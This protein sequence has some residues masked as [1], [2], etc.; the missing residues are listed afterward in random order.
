MPKKAYSGA[1]TAV[2]G[3]YILIILGGS[4]SSGTNIS[5]KNHLGTSFALFFWSGIAPNGSEGQYLAQNE[6]K[7]IYL[8]KVR[9]KSYF[10]CWKRSK[11]FGTHISE[12]QLG[13]SFPLA[14]I[15]PIMTKNASF[16]PNL[17]VLGQKIQIFEGGSKTTLIPGKLLDTCFVFEMYGEQ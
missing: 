9:L 11:S 2:F 8:A 17:A 5:K 4:K 10:F 16:W 15:W 12:N 13:T 14:N 7:C 3:P 1:N 6:Q